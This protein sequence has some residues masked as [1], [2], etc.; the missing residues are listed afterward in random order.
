MIVDSAELDTHYANC[1]FQ[2]LPKNGEMLKGLCNHEKT[3]GKY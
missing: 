3:I 2:F 1:L